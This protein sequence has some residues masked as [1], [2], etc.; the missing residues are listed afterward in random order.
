MGALN[1][2]MSVLDTS[3]ADE[4]DKCFAADVADEDLHKLAE[5]IRY[6][7]HHIDCAVESWR[8]DYFTTKD[9]PEIPPCSC[10]LDEIQESLKP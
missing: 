5:W 2:L 8:R 1:N 7:P 6:A 9:A 4:F 3:T 10:G